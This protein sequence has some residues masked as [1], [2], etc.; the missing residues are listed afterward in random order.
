MTLEDESEHVSPSGA[1]KLKA[2]FSEKPLSP[3]R[4]IV[5]L[6]RDPTL[7]EAGETELAAIVKSTILKVIWMVWMRGPLVPVIVRL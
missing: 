1:E 7:T 4:V 5:E 2:I 6:P 3:V